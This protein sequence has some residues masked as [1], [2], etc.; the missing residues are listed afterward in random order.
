[1]NTKYLLGAAVACF[2]FAGMMGLFLK[3]QDNEYVFV[4]VKMGDRLPASLQESP[5]AMEALKKPIKLRVQE[6]LINSVQVTN[7]PT[8]AS[9][10][11]EQFAAKEKDGSYQL[12]CMVYDHAILTFEAE[13]MAVAGERPKMLIKTP[14]HIQTASV[15]KMKSIIV[16][17]TELK[18]QTPKDGSLTLSGFP[19][20]EYTFHGV[21]GQWPTVWVLKQIEFTGSQKRLTIG[22]AEL[23]E[24]AKVGRVK[25]PYLVW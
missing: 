8:V 14:C 12:S 21:A 25:L 4:Q 23:I 10:E 5:D 3:K 6:E 9:I 15:N 16:P 24:R 18:A 20:T 13:G 17:I 7:T 1:M 22:T 2:A 19:G 11:L